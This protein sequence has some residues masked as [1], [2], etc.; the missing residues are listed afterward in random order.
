MKFHHIGIACDD[1]ETATDFVKNTFH[2]GDVGKIVFDD[3]Q[4]VN[5]RLIKTVCNTHIELVSGVTVARFI[6][7]KQYLYHTCWEVNNI[8][9]SIKC[10]I[11]NGAMLI[12]ESKPAI[13]FDY[14]SVAFLMTD[15]GIVELLESK[16]S[17]Q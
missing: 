11:N 7:K 8:K 5:L 12:S 2:I 9:E 3:N 13:L 15:I 6:K 17:K 10:F 1:I 14:R 16:D 4:N